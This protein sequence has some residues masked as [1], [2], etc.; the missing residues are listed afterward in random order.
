MLPVYPM[1]P[2]PVTGIKHPYCPVCDAKLSKG[3]EHRHM[4][5]YHPEH[6]NSGKVNPD[7]ASTLSQHSASTTVDTIMDSSREESSS[8]DRH[9]PNNDIHNIDQSHHIVQR[10]LIQCVFLCFVLC[11]FRHYFKY[12]E[13]DFIFRYVF[14]AL[15][16]ETTF[17]ILTPV[18]FRIGG[19]ELQKH[20]ESL[21]RGYSIFI[22]LRLLYN[23]ELNIMNDCRSRKVRHGI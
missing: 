10:Q 17:L 9:N 14:V 19:R 11:V 20:L 2:D 12:N 3:N 18:W 4:K 1:K 16:Q 21:V 23:N 15:I 6:C 13:I 8:A 7:G 22:M 5:K